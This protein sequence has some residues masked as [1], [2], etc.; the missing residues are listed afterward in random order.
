M[1]KEGFVE[2]PATMEMR[3]RARELGIRTVWQRYKENHARSKDAPFQ[4]T[5][6]T[7]QQGPCVDVRRTGVCGMSRDVIIAK[8]LVSETAIGAA[9][10]VGHARRVA[11]IMKGVGVGSIK[12]YSVKD[13]DRLN[14]VYDGLGLSGAKSNC[15]RPTPP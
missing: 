11:A 14:E 8:N 15:V 13:T 2:D 10:H 4:A 7:C 3:K 12:G 5:C 9:A 6:T 1:G